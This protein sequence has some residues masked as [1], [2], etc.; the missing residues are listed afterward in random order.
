LKIKRYNKI[1]SFLLAIFFIS[2]G[3]F[4]FTHTTLAVEEGKSSLQQLADMMSDPIAAILGIILK[5]T[6]IFLAMA[7]ALL[8]WT[9]DSTSLNAML[10]AEAI[11]ETWGLVRDILNMF[12]I[13]ILLFS[14]F[15]TVFQYSK[16]NYKSI[17]MWL[18][19]MT[20]LVNFSY[21]ITLFVIDFSNSLMYTILQYTFKSAPSFSM[22]TA[23]GGPFAEITKYIDYTSGRNDKSEL[24]MMII[25]IFILAMTILA[26]AII[27]LIRTIALAIIIVLSPIG[28]IGKIVNK[29]GGWWDHLFK[30][31]MAG[32]LIAFTLLLSVKLMSASITATKTL[33]GTAMHIDGTGFIIPIVILWM[34]IA[35]AIKGIDGSGAVLGKA[36]GLAKALPKGAWKATGIP[37][38]VKKGW[39]NSRKSGKLFGKKIPLLKDGREDRETGIGGFIK[40][41]TKG[42]AKAKEAKKQKEFNEKVK[43][44]QENHNAIDTATLVNNTAGIK[45]TVT[46]SNAL[47]I[48]GQYRQLISDPV[49]KDEHDATLKLQVM[50][51]T[52]HQTAMGAFTG[53]PELIAAQKEA[54]VKQQVAKEWG[55]LRTQFNAAQNM[56][57][58]AP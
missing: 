51:D 28:F 39:E 25:F 55:L 17:L 24:L 49:K 21:P 8:D 11:R 7:I 45:R 57:K 20:L 44:E 58:T 4:L 19:I 38:G 2:A 3:L 31:A 56:Y 1:Y 43:E 10:T 13:M 30:Y 6:G 18:V 29:D 37:G 53:T 16:Y 12:I 47:E 33:N 54:Y 40:D 48:A 15:A 46:A 9:I 22:I 14:A 36:Q 42:F 5:L 35:M 32:P 23:A 50:S 27:L 26:I 41:G 52:T 34:G